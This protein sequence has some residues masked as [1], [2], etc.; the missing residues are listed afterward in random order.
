MKTVSVD[1]IETA[2]DFARTFCNLFA[3]TN[4]AAEARDWTRVDELLAKQSELLQSEKFTVDFEVP[5][6]VEFR[7]SRGSQIA[8][9]AFF[10]HPRGFRK[11]HSV[12]VLAF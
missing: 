2:I 3:A 5:G 12:R 4:N 11:F 9:V 10:D 1:R 6:G 7:V 8:E